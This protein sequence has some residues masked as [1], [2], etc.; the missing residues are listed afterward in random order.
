MRVLDYPWH[1]AHLYR[2]ATC[3]PA[4]FALAEVRRPVWNLAQRP[5]P[6]NVSFVPANPSLSLYDLALLHLDQWCDRLNLRAL[7]F[8]LMKQRTENLPQVVIMHSTPDGEANRL[9]ILRLV[10]DLP[11]VCNS[12]QAA[13]EWDGGEDRVDRYGLPQFRAI[14]HGYAE[15]FFNHPLSQRA[16]AITVCNG[17]ELSREYHGLALVER[18]KRDV[19]LLWYGPNGDRAWKSDYRA[20]RELLASSLIYFSPTRR[21]PMPGART[22]AML[23]GCCVVTVPG[24]D[25]EDFIH[26]WVNGVIV[27]TYAEAR[28]ALRTLLAQPELAYAIGQQGRE[29]ALKIFDAKRYQEDWLSLWQDL[30]FCFFPAR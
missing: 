23:S 11:V 15:E 20:Y 21:A 19:P 8:R 30:R 16:G 17:G 29:D 2:L 27:R 13:M 7:P 6:S 14:I 22:E 4:S 1:Q 9:A 26:S 18:L 5:I 28:D 3:L 10:G 12:R 24:N 25:A